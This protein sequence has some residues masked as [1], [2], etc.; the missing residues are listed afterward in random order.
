MDH[1]NKNLTPPYPGKRPRIAFFDYPDVFEDFYPHYGVTQRTFA[2]SWTNTAN[3]QWIQLI[4][5]EIGD[6]TWYVNCIKPEHS[7][8]KNDEVGCVVKYLP[9]SFFH[10]ILWKQFYLSSSSW[11][12]RRFYRSY[13]SLASY[14]SPLSWHLWKLLRKDKPDVLYVQDYG[15][16]RYDSLLFFAFLLKIPLMTFHSGSI[17]DEYHGMLMR[18]FTLKKADWIFPSGEN[19]QRLLEQKF[20][21]N[22]EKT[23]II[24]P[25][26]DTQA[27][28]P[29]NRDIAC[30]ETGLD[31][32]R[33]YIIFVGRLSDSI[34]RLSI[35]IKVFAEIAIKHD[36][37]DLLIIGNGSDETSLQNYAEKIIPGRVHFKGWVAEDDRKAMFYNV[38]ECLV[39]NSLREASPAVIG[40]AF[41]CGIPVVSSDIGGID[42]LVVQEKSGWLF[43]PGDDDALLRHLEYVAA[44]PEKIKTMRSH[45]R[46]IAEKKVSI[47]VI[48]KALQEGFTKVLENEKQSF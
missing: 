24:R 11:R 31:P 14:L 35:I 43:T 28:R 48:K 6:V 32:A 13:A 33:R 12:W 30:S 41:S 40:E 37:V 7:E 25:P 18:R 2:T 9:S 44:N 20:G 26:I 4:Q 45:V 39:L 10:R 23:S 36:E 34:K 16:G 38:S 42:D 27:Y 29:V 21:I 47:P 46:E 1:I 17:P 5:E 19:E 15:S 3:H 8:L 22:K